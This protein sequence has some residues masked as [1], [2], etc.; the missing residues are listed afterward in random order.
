M[1][2]AKIRRIFNISSKE[3][4]SKRSTGEVTFE[5]EG[6]SKCDM[7]NV[8]AAEVGRYEEA[9]ATGIISKSRK[10]YKSKRKQGDARRER[11]K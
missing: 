5:K 4:T 11:K 7:M 8:E 10:N 9:M 1:K 6:G 2:H 3:L